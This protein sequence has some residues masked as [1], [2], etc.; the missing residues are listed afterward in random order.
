MICLLMLAPRV[1]RKNVWVVELRILFLSLHFAPAR[2]APMIQASTCLRCPDVTTYYSCW[3]LNARR[4]FYHNFHYVGCYKVTSG[5]Y[6]LWDKSI[7]G[8]N[9][10]CLV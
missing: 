8:S 9:Q 5:H 6:F 1:K 7:G 4:H 2:L 3:T 10:R